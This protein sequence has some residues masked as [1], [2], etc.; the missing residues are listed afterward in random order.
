MSTVICNRAGRPCMAGGAA[1]A[2]D[3]ER[4]GLEAQAEKSTATP[5]SA[6]RER[7]F[8]MVGK[9]V[10]DLDR[11]FR[12]RSPSASRAGQSA[13]SASKGSSFAARFAGSQHAMIA[14]TP[15]A[16]IAS[17]S[18]GTAIPLMP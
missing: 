13:R 17:A 5:A 7:S 14:A 16:T 1:T 9:Y 15:T 2:V 11:A 12:L 18:G 8:F 6:A 4:M 3:G 10:P